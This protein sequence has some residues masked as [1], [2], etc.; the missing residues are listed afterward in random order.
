M[1]EP[2][3]VPVTVPVCVKDRVMVPVNVAVAG[4][5]LVG[6]PD[7]LTDCDSVRVNVTGS[8][9]DLVNVAE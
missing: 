3:R 6:V 4:C 1:G 7:K 8:V 5:V 2:E 9:N